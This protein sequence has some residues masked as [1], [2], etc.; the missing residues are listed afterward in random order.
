MLV[1]L[2]FTVVLAL[3]LGIGTAHALVAESESVTNTRGYQLLRSGD[4][5]GAITVFLENVIH[6]RFTDAYRGMAL[7]VEAR[8]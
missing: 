6:V 1:R 5:Q 2:A 3:A 7:P 4:F 8:P